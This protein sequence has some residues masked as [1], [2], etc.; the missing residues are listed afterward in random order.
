LFT[1]AVPDGMTV[2]A[3]VRVLVSFGRSKTYLGIV[4]RVHSVKPEG[5]E[6]KPI[7]Q[8][9]DAAPIVYEAQLKLWLWIADYYMSPIGDVYKAAMPAGL[10][11]E[12]GY[13]PK[14]ETYIRLTEQYRNVTALHIAL[15]VLSRAK[16]QLEAFTCYLA[17]SHW[18]QL[19]N[20]DHENTGKPHPLN[21]SFFQSLKKN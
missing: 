6:V 4:A 15:N 20:E 8:V 12:D 9:M 21:L 1:Y 19:R 16:K 17:L 7:L 10:K 18:D 13:R 3:G 11:S 2:Q 5:Y 14:T